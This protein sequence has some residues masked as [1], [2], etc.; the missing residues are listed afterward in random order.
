M[1]K[2][3]KLE[4]KAET[5]IDSIERAKVLGGWFVVVNA[6]YGNGGG[7]GLTFMPDPEHKWD[8]KSL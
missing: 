3:E 4:Y 5:R 2:F 8:G 1:L 6:H 7:A